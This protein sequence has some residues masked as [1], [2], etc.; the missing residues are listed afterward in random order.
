MV[1]IIAALT[2]I[3]VALGFLFVS[4]AIGS[5]LARIN[6]L[7]YAGVALLIGALIWLGAIL[8]SSSLSSNPFVVSY[9][10]L[11]QQTVPSGLMV[12]GNPLLGAVFSIIGI[13]EVGMLVGYGIGRH[14][15]KV[16]TLPQTYNRLPLENRPRF[17]N[18][19][20]EGQ[21]RRDDVVREQHPSPQMS[22]RPTIEMSSDQK[23]LG[24]SLSADERTI[25]QLFLFGGVSEI[26]PTLDDK[27]P[28]GYYFEQLQNLDW[29][30]RR[31][32]NTLN[33]LAKRGFVT[34]MPRE[35]ILHCRNCDSTNLE[36]RGSCPEC[37]SLA[38]TKHKVLEHF[39]CGMIEKESTFRTPNGDLL[40]PKCNRKL[41]LIGNDYR[42]LGLMYVCQN[43]GALSKDLSPNL[44]CRNCG[45]T[46][47]PD[48]ER[49]QYVYGY[50]LNPSMLQRLR[51]YVKPIEVVV[52]HYKSIGYAVYSPS[53]V[54]GR[55]GTEQAFDL[56]ILNSGSN[57]SAGRAAF[58]ELE[59]GKIVADILISDKP[60]E[61]ED[62]T[63]EYGKISDVN[64][65]SIL[66]VVP[67]LSEKAQSY[68][69]AYRMRICEGRTI[70][71]A[72]ASATRNLASINKL[73]TKQS[74]S[75]TPPG[76][77]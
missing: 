68:A 37:A 49:E 59:R 66:F 55:S 51:Q 23:F 11:Y 12:F 26:K 74:Q 76:T 17:L 35:K 54:R 22:S 6:S 25:A 48:E 67:S 42:S 72:L 18:S 5:G 34:P 32:T 39:S 29:D 53:F 38:L 27:S 19:K 43:C 60:I 46:T 73:T 69:S 63:R 64:Y 61:L 40:C 58:D 28:E 24:S 36:F 62:I 52:N 13:I 41:E 4:L 47:S 3:T 71:Q 44:K 30:T 56:M 1:D 15:H 70:E 57:N 45:F 21:A 10:S 33:T 9:V 75:A 31:Q 77:E 65:P 8:L 16:N 14:Y 2:I 50:S 20:G 7:A